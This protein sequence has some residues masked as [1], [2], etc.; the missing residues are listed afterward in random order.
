MSA[1]CVGG[2]HV[3]HV[4]FEPDKRLGAAGQRRA[5]QEAAD[6]ILLTLFPREA[7][8]DIHWMDGMGLR[9]VGGEHGT[10]EPAR[11]Q[12]ETRVISHVF[13]HKEN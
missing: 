4:E 6:D 11:Q 5:A 9:F 7:G 10:V 1:Q 13:S 2:V 3:A 8:G 12:H